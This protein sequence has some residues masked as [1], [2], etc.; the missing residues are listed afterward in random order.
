[1]KLITIITL[2]FF[3]TTLYANVK[4]TDT[5]TVVFAT[6]E[7]GKALLGKKDDFV[8]RLSPFDRAARLKTGQPVT[9][10]KYLE[11]V[12]SSVLPW[13]DKDKELL[14]KA[15]IQVGKSLAGYSLPLPKQIIMIKTSG[16]EEAHAAYT[17]ANAIMFGE[18]QMA[19]KEDRMQYLLFHELFHVLSR[20]DSQLKH[21]LYR[22]I[23]FH[24][25]NDL[26]F[27]HSLKAKKLTNPDAPINDHYIQLMHNNKL[28][29]T[30]PI[31][32]S[33][34][35]NYDMKKGGEFFNY[36]SFQLLVVDHDIKSGQMTPVINDGKPV[37]LSPK[38]VPDFS[39]Q[40]GQNTGYIIH[41]EEILAD[42]FSF[43]MTQRADL[44]SPNIV[45]QIKQ[46]LEQ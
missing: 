31:L 43:L 7:Q 12:K 8:S 45:K 18:K 17:R 41:P 25:A 5:T 44:K 2:L 24:Q 26:Q 22:V 4:I 27:P 14:T 19:F 1:M 29:K 11:F 36:L 38:D 37:L 15:Y 6:V 21:N 10:A 30:V 3:S 46:I 23:G 20:A 16:N 33:T 39:K 13:T 35:D 34:S 28:I 9:T 40:I 42:N 32:F